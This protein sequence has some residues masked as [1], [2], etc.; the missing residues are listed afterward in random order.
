MLMRF[1]FKDS[2][3]LYQKKKNLIYTGWATKM[4]PLFE[5]SITQ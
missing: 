5:S 1:L 4:Y 2:Q 3:V